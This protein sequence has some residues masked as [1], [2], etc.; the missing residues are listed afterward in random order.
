MISARVMLESA[1]SFSFS[2]IFKLVRG[3]PSDRVRTA[4]VKGLLRICRELNILSGAEGIETLE[5]FSRLVELGVDLAQGFHVG[6]P[7]H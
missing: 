4:I 1:S 6:R 3:L 2:R 7:I 5:E